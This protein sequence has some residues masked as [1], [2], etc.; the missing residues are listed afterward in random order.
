MG[1]LIIWRKWYLSAA[2]NW[3]GAQGGYI[4]YRPKIKF[5]F[6]WSWVIPGY[7]GMIPT[8]VEKTLASYQGE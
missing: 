2:S 6:R 3:P 4:S 7:M 8:P 1:M 5:F